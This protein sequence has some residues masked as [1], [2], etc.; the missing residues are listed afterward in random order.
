MCGVHYHSLPLP[1]GDL[2]NIN[3]QIGVHTRTPGGGHVPQCPIAGDTNEHLGLTTTPKLK[4]REVV[5]RGDC[6]AELLSVWV[7]CRQPKFTFLQN[8]GVKKDSLLYVET[9]AGVVVRRI[10]DAGVEMRTCLQHRK[11]CSTV[12]SLPRRAR[13]NCQHQQPSTQITA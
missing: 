2:C 13:V 6:F 10:A 8:T 3:C 5:F 12:V 1:T 9:A 4:Q 7:D 11:V